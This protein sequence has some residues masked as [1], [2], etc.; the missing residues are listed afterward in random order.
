VVALN[1]G[2]VDMLLAQDIMTRKVVTVR[3]DSTISEAAAQMVR[4]RISAVPVVDDG[5]LVGII[6]EGDLVHRAE[7]GTAERSRSWWL[8]LFRDPSTMAKE[9]ARSHSRHV[10]DLMTRT[11]RS[12][13]EKASVEQI[14]ELMDR[15]RIKRVPVTRGGAVVGIVSRAD[16]VKAIAGARP[17]YTDAHPSDE[18]IRARLLEELGLQPWASAT[19][20][21][22]EV[23]DGFVSFW[24]T[25][26]SEEERRASRILAE[27]L[28]GV[29]GVE[30][31]R[32]AIDFPAY[33]L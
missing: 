14:A 20:I 25:V 8:T 15:A 2:G 11:V 28:A 6:S 4:H 30:D 27:N 10:A 1:Q 29:R 7:I 33:A 31:H 5:L 17:E 16:L 24:G 13:E 22:V 12:V 18:G 19:Q 32:L 21:G 9:Y 26:N 23:R 3:P